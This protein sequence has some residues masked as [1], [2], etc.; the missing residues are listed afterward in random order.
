MPCLRMNS[1]IPRAFTEFPGRTGSHF[2]A[3]I[4]HLT[5]AEFDPNVT[6]RIA[7]PSTLIGSLLNGFNFVFAENILSVDFQFLYYCK[8][9]T[10][11]FAP[12]SAITAAKVL[13]TTTSTLN[14][15]W[16]WFFRIFWVVIL[17]RLTLS[18]F[19]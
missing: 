16:Y 17:N 1:I 11:T 3:I 14:F 19:S 7:C 13:F 2:A 18:T 12:V 10:L 15:P 9:Q 4:Y 8:L 6:A 5:R